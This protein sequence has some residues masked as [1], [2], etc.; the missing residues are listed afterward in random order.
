MSCREDPYRFITHWLWTV[1]TADEKNPVK[2]FP[3]KVHLHTII[4]YWLYYPMLLIPKSRQMSVTWVMTAI[5]IWHAFYFPHRINFIQSKKEE[6]A[7]EVLERMK[8][9]YDNLPVWMRSWNPA[10]KTY[11]RMEFQ[12]NKSR[13]IAIPSGAEHIRSYQASAIFNDETVYQTEV[14]KMLAAAK[15]S[16]K[17]GGRIT[18][19][20]SA[21]PSVFGAMVNDEV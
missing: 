9:L 11:C 2:L 12:R 8:I 4:K 20:S 14:D 1:D 5:Y 6:D 3:N 13:V 17:S 19:V 7:D 18:L 21:G 10:E 15:P 16:I